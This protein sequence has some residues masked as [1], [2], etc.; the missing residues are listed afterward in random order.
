MKNKQKAWRLGATVM[1][2]RA[3]ANKETATILGSIFREF[4]Q[5]LPAVHRK[6]EALKG[7]NEGRQFCRHTGALL[8]PW[9]GYTAQLGKDVDGYV[10]ALNPQA[11][12][13]RSEAWTALSRVWEII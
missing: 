5:R 12:R 11:H 8:A 10:L 4:P 1:G 7:K 6:R 13:G 2:R 3:R 9:T